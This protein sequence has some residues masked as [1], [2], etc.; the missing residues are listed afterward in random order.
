MRRIVTAGAIVALAC[1][2]AL[3]TDVQTRAGP[4]DFRGSSALF[5]LGD[6][7]VI[8]GNATLTSGRPISILQLVISDLPSS[9]SGTDAGIPPGRHGSLNVTLERDRPDTVGP[10]TYRFRDSSSPTAAMVAFYPFEA[11]CDGFTLFDVGGDIELWR[12]DEGSA[13]GKID[14]SLHDGTRLE[15]T[16]VASRCPLWGISPLPDGGYGQVSPPVICPWAQP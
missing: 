8:D 6:S 7:Y 1:G 5:A 4:T 14:V 10:G 2:G 15:G 13:E 16:F 11:S 3:E 12:L 9:C